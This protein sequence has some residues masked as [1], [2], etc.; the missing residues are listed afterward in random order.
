MTVSY[1]QLQI[2]LIQINMLNQ[3]SSASKLCDT[4]LNYDG[5][6][7]DSY[8]QEKIRISY[9]QSIYRTYRKQPA[10]YTSLKLT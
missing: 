6:H 9:P 7:V 8:Y 3:I 4:D 10:S 2:F 1:P 5:Y